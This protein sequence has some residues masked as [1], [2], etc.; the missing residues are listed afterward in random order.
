M[1]TKAT[2]REGYAVEIQAAWFNALTRMAEL[3]PLGAESYRQEADRVEKSFNRL[4]WN[5][6]EQTVFD[7][8]GTQGY[9][10]A[11][12]S[13][14]SGKADP[15]VRANQVL[16]VY[17]GITQGERSR[18][19]LQSTERRL[20]V[21]G[22]VR[23]LARPQKMY[24]PDDRDEATRQQDNLT[25]R[26]IGW[27]KG[28]AEHYYE[29]Y[30][31]PKSWDDPDPAYHNGT[32]WVWLYAFYWIAAVRTGYVS[33]AKAEEVMMKDYQEMLAHPF[34][35]GNR[36]YGGSLP[37]IKDAEPNPTLN[38]GSHDPK[39]CKTQTWSLTSAILGLSTVSPRFRSEVWPGGGESSKAALPPIRYVRFKADKF[40]SSIDDIRQSL[41]RAQAVRQS[42][43]RGILEAA[44]ARFSGKAAAFIGNLLDQGRIRIAD[45][46]AEAVYVS[47]TLYLD[48]TLFAPG[49]EG[50][51]NRCLSESANVCSRAG[52]FVL[53]VDAEGLV[54]TFGKKLEELGEVS[55]D[56]A[57]DAPAAQVKDGIL[58]LNPK[59]LHCDPA[60]IHDIWDWYAYEFGVEYLW[61]KGL[62]EESA[63]SN[64]MGKI[65]HT[66][67]IQGGRDSRSLVR[68]GSK[69][70]VYDYRVNPHL[71][72]PGDP[73]QNLE[74]F[75]ARRLRP[76]GLTPMI[77]FVTN[78]VAST[79]PL[80]FDEATRDLFYSWASEREFFDWA[81]QNLGRPN[82]SDEELR[83]E[84]TGID[85]QFSWVAPGM[86]GDQETKAEE[87]ENWAKNGIVPD[88]YTQ[89]RIVWRGI[90]GSIA[91][92]RPNYSKP[93]NRRKFAALLQ[94]LSSRMKGGAFRADLAHNQSDE[95]WE[96]IA[97]GVPEAFFLFEVYDKNV[98][99]FMELIRRAG[100]NGIVYDKR[101]IDQLKTRAQEIRNRLGISDQL[102]ALLTAM[103]ANHDEH[104]GL[105]AYQTASHARAAGI[106]S[107]VNGGPTLLP[108]TEFVPEERPAGLMT[109]MDN[110]RDAG[111]Y[112]VSYDFTKLDTSFIA[113]THFIN[114]R[115]AWSEG[116][117]LPVLAE[118]VRKFQTDTALALVP[119]DNGRIHNVIM[120]S[121]S[122]SMENSGIVATCRRWSDEDLVTIVN[123]SDVPTEVT[124][125]L[126]RM[127][128][129]GAEPIEGELSEVLFSEGA[130]ARQAPRTL[131]VEL[132]A[133]GH[134][135]FSFRRSEK[136][137]RDAANVRDLVAEAH[138]QFSKKLEEGGSDAWASHFYNKYLGSLEESSG[139]RAIFE[140]A[141]ERLLF[142][143][144]PTIRRG[145]AWIISHSEFLGPVSFANP[146][147]SAQLVAL[148]GDHKDRSVLSLALD[149]STGGLDFVTRFAQ[150]MSTQRQH[151]ILAELLS[152]AMTVQDTNFRALIM[153]RV[154]DILPV[155]CPLI[156]EA[157]A[158]QTLSGEDVTLSQTLDQFNSVPV[159]RARRLIEAV[160]E[161][162]SMIYLEECPIV[163]STK[164][165]RLS[166]RKTS[167]TLRDVS[168]DSWIEAQTLGARLQTVQQQLFALPTDA[169]G[170]MQVFALSVN[171]STDLLL[172]GDG[173]QG[174]ILP[175]AFSFLPDQD[176]AKNQP[177]IYLLF[178]PSN[179]ACYN[180]VTKAS[181]LKDGLPV[182]IPS[183]GQTIHFIA[184][185]EVDRPIIMQVS[186]EFLGGVDKLDQNLKRLLQDIRLPNG[187][188]IYF[189]GAHEKGQI[190]K[191][192]A[193]PRK[194]TAN[195]LYAVQG[196][197]RF[198][199]RTVVARQE[200]NPGRGLTASA[201]SVA[202]LK[203]PAVVQ[204]IGRISPWL[205]KSQIRPILDLTGHVTPDS[206]CVLEHPDWFEPFTDVPGDWKTEIPSSLT[207][208]QILETQGIRE[209]GGAWAFLWYGRVDADLRKR[210][211]DRGFIIGDEVV[212]GRPTG[213]VRLLIR[214]H[215]GLGPMGDTAVFNFKLPEVQDYL[216]SVFN[217]WLKAQG[218]GFRVDLAYYFPVE[219]LARFKKEFPD[220]FIMTEY[221]TSFGWTVDLQ[222][223][224]G[225]E[226]FYNHEE[227]WKK[228]KQSF[229]GSNSSQPIQEWLYDYRF[230]LTLGAFVNYVSNHDEDIA[231]CLFG[232]HRE[233]Y[234]A[235]QAIL[236]H[237]PGYFMIN[238]PDALGWKAPPYS[239]GG[240]TKFELL[241]ELTFGRMK[242]IVSQATTEA[243]S[244]TFEGLPLDTKVSEGINRILA[245]AASPVIRRGVAFDV[246]TR[247]SNVVQFS[248]SYRGKTETV[249]VNYSDT[250]QETM[251]AGQM[252]YF[253]PWEG[254]IF[255]TDG[256]TV[257][258]HGLVNNNPWF[259]KAKKLYGDGMDLSWAKRFCDE[260]RAAFQGQSDVQFQQTFKEIKAALRWI[261]KVAPDNMKAGAKWM[262]ET[263]SADAGLRDQMDYVLRREFEQV[264]DERDPDSFVARRAAS[265]LLEDTEVIPG[266]R[267]KVF[268]YVNEALGA[269]M[270]QVATLRNLYHLQAGLDRQKLGELPWA[271]AWLEE[272]KA[273]W[274]GIWDGTGVVDWKSDPKLL[275][276]HGTVL[277]WNRQPGLMRNGAQWI[278]F[279]PASPFSSVFL[280]H[281]RAQLRGLA[282]LF[283][284]GNPSAL[285]QMELLFDEISSIPGL[286]LCLRDALIQFF[287]E[288]LKAAFLRGD[289]SM[290]DTLGRFLSAISDDAL[291][292]DL[293]LSLSRAAGDAS[294][295]CPVSDDGDL[296]LG[297]LLELEAGF[298]ESAHP[299]PWAGEMARAH[300]VDIREERF[301]RVFTEKLLEWNRTPGRFQGGARWIL[302]EDGSEFS[303]VYLSESRM[304]LAH[305]IQ[306][307]QGGDTTAV[308]DLKAFLER[309]GS[310][311]GL[312]S[313]LTD[314]TLTALDQAIRVTAPIPNS[315]A[316]VWTLLSLEADLL[317]TG[318]RSDG[319]AGEFVS[320]HH[321]QFRNASF[322][323]PFEGLLLLWNEKD[324]ESDP[325]FLAA[326]WI[327]MKSDFSTE[328]FKPYSA[329]INSIADPQTDRWFDKGTELVSASRAIPGLGLKIVGE[330]ES[331]LK[332]ELPR[333]RAASFHVIA[334][335]ILAQTGVQKTSRATLAAVK[336]FLSRQMP[337]LSTS[338][339]GSR[340]STMDK[341]RRELDTAK[342]LLNPFFP[343]LS[344]N[345]FLALVQAG[346]FLA[347]ALQEAG[348]S[349]PNFQSYVDYLRSLWALYGERQIEARRH[350]L[351]EAPPAEG[352]FESAS[353]LQLYFERLRE[354]NF[355]KVAPFEPGTFFAETLA[356]DNGK[357]PWQ[358]CV[359]VM[360]YTRGTDSP[361]A[362]AFFAILSKDPETQ[363]NELRVF[364][365]VFNNFGVQEMV[366]VVPIK[367]NT[368]EGDRIAFSERL[369]DL[370]YFQGSPSFRLVAD[371]NQPET[372]WLIALKSGKPALYTFNFHHFQSLDA[373]Q[374]PGLNEAN[375]AGI[376]AK[377]RIRTHE[378]S[379]NSGM[380]RMELLAKGHWRKLHRSFPT[381]GARLAQSKPTFLRAVPVAR[382][383][384]DYVSPVA[385]GLPVT[386]TFG[387]AFQMRSEKDNGVFNFEN[388]KQYVEYAAIVGDHLIQGLP[389]MVPDGYSNSPYS[390]ESGFL[391]NPESLSIQALF[392]DFPIP[393]VV[394]EW[395][396]E[397]TQ[398]EVRRLNRLPRTNH[399]A[400]L[401][402]NLKFLG[403]VWKELESNPGW[404]ERLGVDPQLESQY[405]SFLDRFGT[406]LTDE[407]LYIEL[408][409]EM[410][411]LDPETGWDWR[412]WN[413]WYDGLS[414]YGLID[415]AETDEERACVDKAG[416]AVSEARSRHRQE[417]T[418]GLFVQ[419]M[420][421]RQLRSLMRFGRE[422]NVEHAI[423]DPYGPPAATVWR[424]PKIAGLRKENGYK[425]VETMG[426]PA[427]GPF[428]AGQF[429]QFPIF[430]WDYDGTR[431]F[432]LGKDEFY[433]DLGFRVDRKDHELGYYRVC[434]F[435]EDVDNE[436]SWAWADLSWHGL[437]IFEHIRLLR[438]AVLAPNSDEVLRKINTFPYLKSIRNLA[439][440]H[441]IDEAKNLACAQFSEVVLWPM[442]GD[443]KANG[444]TRG[445]PPDALQNLISRVADPRHDNGLLVARRVL[446]PARYGEAAPSPWIRQKIVEK[447]IFEG[448]PFWDFIRLTPSEQ[449]EDRGFIKD[450]LFPQ[451]E[452]NAPR[453]DDSLRIIYFKLAPAE[454]ILSQ[455]ARFWQEN[456]M[457]GIGEMLGSV[458]PSTAKSTY[459]LEITN[460]SPMVWNLLGE[461]IEDAFATLSLHDSLSQRTSWE[462][463]ALPEEVRAKIKPE[464]ETGMSWDQ[465]QKTLAAWGI[466]QADWPKHRLYT[467]LVHRKALETIYFS[468]ALMVVPGWLD[469]YGL[470]DSYRANTPGVQ[471]NQWELRLPSEATIEN[472]IRAARYL[473]LMHPEWIDLDV[474]ADEK[475][476]GADLEL[477]GIPRKVFDAVR[478]HLHLIRLRNKFWR[479][480][481]C[482]ARGTSKLLRTRPGVGGEIRQYRS[483]GR[484]FLV[485]QYVWDVAHS[486]T[487]VVDT[488]SGEL[489]IPM[490]RCTVASG[491]PEG[492]TKWTASCVT[493]AA[494]RYPFHVEVV[495][496]QG[497]LRS[498][499]GALIARETSADENP[500][501]PEYAGKTGAR[502]SAR[503]FHFVLVEPT[504]RVR[505]ILELTL[506]RFGDKA[507]VSSFATTE[508]ASAAFGQA[509]AVIGTEEVI[510]RVRAEKPDLP[511]LL[512]VDD[513]KL[514]SATAVTNAEEVIKDRWERAGEL[515]AELKAELI[516]R[517]SSSLALDVMGA[518]D[519]IIKQ[520]ESGSR[521]SSTWSLETARSATPSLKASLEWLAE[522]Q[523]ESSVNL[524]KS[525]DMLWLMCSDSLEAAYQAGLQWR[526]SGRK[527][528]PILVTGGIGSGSR[529]I[530]QMRENN[531]FSNPDFAS[532][533]FEVLDRSLDQL[534][535]IRQR[536]PDLFWSILKDRFHIER[537]FDARK[538]AEHDAIR[539][540]GQEPSGTETWEH[541][542]VQRGIF[543]AAE[544]R[545]TPIEELIFARLLD[546]ATREDML[547]PEGIVNDA[548]LEALGVPRFLRKVEA[549]S[550]TSRENARYGLS[551]LSEKRIFPRR[552]TVM[553]KPVSQRRAKAALE[554]EIEKALPWKGVKISSWAPF[555]Y[556]VDQLLANEDAPA[557]FVLARTAVW[558]IDQIQ[559]HSA[560]GKIAPRTIPS[561]VLTARGLL[562]MVL[563]A[564]LADV[565]EHEDVPLLDLTHVGDFGLNIWAIETDHLIIVPWEEEPGQ[566]RQNGAQVRINKGERVEIPI[567]EYQVW[568]IYHRVSY[569]NERKHATLTIEG[570][571]LADVI[572]PGQTK[573][574]L[575]PPNNTFFFGETAIARSRNED[576]KTVFTLNG[577]PLSFNPDGIS[578]WADRGLRG[579]VRQNGQVD[580]TN[581]TQ[582]PVLH[583][584]RLSSSGGARLASSASLDLLSAWDA[585]EM[586]S[587]QLDEAIAKSPERFKSASRLL[588]EDVSFFGFKT[589]DSL[590][591]AKRNLERSSRGRGA[592][593][594]IS[595]Q[596][597]LDAI[598]HTFSAIYTLENF[599]TTS[600]IESLEEEFESQPSDLRDRI[601]NV[602]L[603]R[604]LDLTNHAY[605]FHVSQ[606]ERAEAPGLKAALDTLASATRSKTGLLEAI[607]KV[608]Q[609]LEW[610]PEPPKYSIGGV[611]EP[612]EKDNDEAA[613]AIQL[614]SVAGNLFKMNESLSSRPPSQDAV[615]FTG[616]SRLAQDTR[617]AQTQKLWKDIVSGGAGPL[618]LHRGAASAF[619]DAFEQD[620][621][622]N[623]DRLRAIRTQINE[624]SL[625]EFSD[626][627]DEVLREIGLDRGTFKLRR[628]GMLADLTIYSL[629]L[630]EIFDGKVGLDGRR[631]AEDYIRNI[632]SHLRNEEEMIAS[633]S[634]TSGRRSYHVWNDSAVAFW[635]MVI[636]YKGPR[637]VY[638][639][640]PWE[641][642]VE[643]LPETDPRTVMIGE[644][645]QRAVARFPETA[646]KT[647]EDAVLAEKVGLANPMRTGFQKQ[648]EDVLLMDRSQATDLAER[649]TVALLQS[650]MPLLFT[651]S[652]NQVGRPVTFGRSRLVCYMPE[653]FLQSFRSD[654]P[655]DM[656]VFTEYM[657]FMLKWFKAYEAMK[658]QKWSASDMYPVLSALTD[659]F[660]RRGQREGEPIRRRLFA[661]ML[662]NIVTES[663]ALVP[664]L[665][666]QYRDV[667]SK[668]PDRADLA[669]MRLAISKGGTSSPELAQ[670]KGLADQW[671]SLGLYFDMLGNHSLAEKAFSE[672]ERYFRE[673]QACDVGDE[674]IRLQLFLTL[675]HLRRGNYGLFLKNLDILL[676]GNKLYQPGSD[677]L[678][679]ALRAGQV[680]MMV[681][682]AERIFNYISD[683][684]H[685]VLGS[686]LAIEKADQPKAR[687]IENVLRQAE[688]KLA[689]FERRVDLRKKLL[690]QWTFQVQ[691]AGL[692]EFETKYFAEVHPSELAE[693]IRR[694]EASGAL[695][696]G[697]ILKLDLRVWQKQG[698][699]RSASSELRS[700]KDFFSRLAG[701]AIGSNT[702]FAMQEGVKRLNGGDFKVPVYIQMFASGTTLQVRLA[703]SGKGRL[704]S[705]TLN[706]IEDRIRQ[707]GSSDVEV[708]PIA[709]D[710]PDEVLGYQVILKFDMA[711]EGT[712]ARLAGVQSALRP[713]GRSRLSP[714]QR[715][716]W[717][718]LRAQARRAGYRSLPMESQ[719]ERPKTAPSLFVAVPNRESAAAASSLLPKSVRILTVTGEPSE[720]LVNALHHRAERVSRQMLFFDMDVNP[721]NQSAF[722]R[723]ISQS[724]ESSGF[725]EAQREESGKAVLVS[726]LTGQRELQDLKGDELS[727]AVAEL[728]A[729]L[730]KIA[731]KRFKEIRSGDDMNSALDQVRRSLF[732]PD[733]GY[734][735]AAHIRHIEQPR[736][737]VQFLSSLLKNP[738]F[739]EA[740][741]Y[742]DE[743]LSRTK[744]RID[745][746]VIDDV[747][748][749]L[750]ELLGDR[751]EAF[752]ARFVDQ[753]RVLKL[754][755]E[756]LSV[757]TVFEAVKDQGKTSYE[758]QNVLFVECDGDRSFGALPEGGHLTKL[759]VRGAY[760]GY[761][762]AVVEILKAGGRPLAIAIRGLNLIGRNFFFDA[763]RRIIDEYVGRFYMQKKAS[764]A[765][766]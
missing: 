709:G 342:C 220:L 538:K 534:A 277:M 483:V 215:K 224:T 28:F 691:S 61:L 388:A 197:D 415:H 547:V 496:P 405:A 730:P 519:G 459:Q 690:A 447:W 587:S 81:R 223:W 544:L 189:V 487:L 410:L 615:Q 469:L 240:R 166:G 177:G 50:D 84:L 416:A 629:A 198:A 406:N 139:F 316:Q 702:V 667:V 599:F 256:Q 661:L 559:K 57:A 713:I 605:I 541:E 398:Q 246:P 13:K 417:I 21:P 521:L 300:S 527:N 371:E 678:S 314:M 14:A 456:G 145:A 422:R 125:C 96:D 160:S 154:F 549:V 426:I 715:Q 289:V 490:T 645:I 660:T 252:R 623:A 687:K 686:M 294:K 550:T 56:V 347:A 710:R 78:A 310:V 337:D 698:R 362:V 578:Q 536:D 104:T 752:V 655:E 498:L 726:L 503:P 158:L 556:D 60:L 435:A 746:Y 608:E 227:L 738:R 118:H 418:F 473:T 427:E 263:G 494:G 33:S 638:K 694:Q 408:K 199:D 275:A 19:I 185:A 548:I 91:S 622:F 497:I 309:T 136:N 229:L 421:Q 247:E 354:V 45:M 23:S 245:S 703:F 766:A 763:P 446:D 479:E 419:F 387:A 729:F 393:S 326:N 70:D 685:Y 274:A 304:K 386:G 164:V 584:L 233:K 131:I 93:E 244:Q 22:A 208:Q 714:A 482:L 613:A 390:S 392:K 105:E 723:F 320:R 49:R 684:I 565:T 292:A 241:R 688:K 577:E 450:Y 739:L 672:T 148:L 428:P 524:L 372:C 359:K 328:F 75:V 394:Q 745:D 512:L 175:E 412:T 553:H 674:P 358:A 436:N 764:A 63:L 570:A 239:D 617:A 425:R 489:R 523:G 135:F 363:K 423:D 237:L 397:E 85:R 677:E 18:L 123:D 507:K 336:A 59:Y 297:A 243:D 636:G 477:N 663:A 357:D 351:A 511:V 630:S 40:M 725:A 558:E 168:P 242:E 448:Q 762:R 181:L 466:P 444:Q 109:S 367:Y 585:F 194:V 146:N 692:S 557:L 648:I 124:L 616:G 610:M 231:M 20:L 731:P 437:T 236:A 625:S 579:V 542:F 757:E 213:R 143:N 513:L 396:K 305:L 149:Y 588:E 346:Q 634:L 414:D 741:D 484:P 43:W 377:A 637:A 262:V 311:P 1:D 267:E 571:R 95:T 488:P 31:A 736:A 129:A 492:V 438:Q 251:I 260:C 509:D 47:G 551:L 269:R 101:F 535:A 155:A 134:A 157:G 457:T 67:D 186:V 130:K 515:A 319:W 115:Q 740:L 508:E 706:Q 167:L 176:T 235:M 656:E 38:D 102:Q 152:A 657:V 593:A 461:I 103:S 259:E 539:A 722:L 601:V 652:Y 700:L 222:R 182:Q 721:E 658:S 750:R 111:I 287:Q 671:A 670:L 210:L 666:Q 676:T 383:D 133:Y 214:H 312:R 748:T 76:K 683:E 480:R 720:R 284:E 187:S 443:M 44:R 234:L 344:D 261:F 35:D 364:S 708:A 491:L 86:F 83:G 266:A 430:D 552:I 296:R 37:E 366:R 281:Y 331:R 356:R 172:S 724:K 755:L 52:K 120:P 532:R 173:H 759:T 128:P 225:V 9:E 545:R 271:G 299:G 5:E 228:M 460:Y 575:L 561:L 518:A 506:K 501:S 440:R 140:Q 384:F 576:H 402:L 122:D 353:E 264:R 73:N 282:N 472:Q 329:I 604:A 190:G 591:R 628:R 743:E 643:V 361:R 30:N 46:D 375:A 338:A 216:V 286:T 765:S 529:T 333:D 474:A 504:D 431:R 401:Q 403:L 568:V 531:D 391:I 106:L 704:L 441:Q 4:F 607:Q 695:R 313:K 302:L 161:K 644:A 350:A 470:D 230:Y 250:V 211:E 280:G 348:G 373:A 272:R 753:N 659:A 525:S 665:I 646:Q 526:R 169:P 110:W 756:H 138:R 339:I 11:E 567:G 520:F 505:K 323:V 171:G 58:H 295:N 117:G 253:L 732:H 183:G 609:A 151:W 606:S 420:M 24:R 590:I 114:A 586:A 254:R 270:A 621:V 596:G 25:R 631:F 51:L 697:K 219:L 92:A 458:L 569:R 279:D 598:Q 582:R 399:W 126:D 317:R 248:R 711:A 55:M 516:S 467:P 88:R 290:Q 603:A 533:F 191:D 747:G 589:Y 374:V 369:D 12:Q 495:T 719:L 485:D 42:S 196:K 379:D 370:P 207:D 612:G 453:A 572:R 170:A 174:K 540:G 761:E 424:D 378:A 352:V 478:L 449:L 90:D 147:D 163:D 53:E 10:S 381:F 324:D 618:Q 2:P 15:A 546:P 137:Q 3:D 8:L 653:R 409:K 113:A 602:C 649:A 64:G 742:R 455:I 632:F 693:T 574:F 642:R 107:L 682:D 232:G 330:I 66:L 150:N 664:G 212:D 99:R 345:V 62:W 306:R 465:K 265:E 705:R 413:R 389:I 74:K 475:V 87:I 318:P 581:E 517:K 627:F 36:L 108:F 595:P 119:K 34:S 696:M 633:L 291:R 451:D 100:L 641:R 493:D 528:L 283:L 121:F 380:G 301:K 349:S 195:H 307:L 452:S 159:I 432:I 298:L 238:F 332:T 669:R 597:V 434:H 727:S 751:T 647:S 343:G 48:S 429:W 7:I 407:L 188:T 341:A 80:V 718:Y 614:L 395:E 258:E 257:E 184:P 201:F 71:V 640:K 32:A 17:F 276:L 592:L 662:D 530:R 16:A 510:R 132:P 680:R 594:S 554:K 144:E 624:W 205:A 142:S 273:S 200:S 639:E 471:T 116:R 699:H 249:V 734:R 385:A 735:V 217:E 376:L 445:L 162:A 321:D 77:D 600:R 180:V 564:R 716:N 744:M 285:G 543:T 41:T 303:G 635:N 72:G 156:A 98:G 566:P 737:R 468:L 365:Y 626:R 360:K 404:A 221:Y 583:K 442:L 340:L 651:D 69:Y 560:A 79:S 82:A 322:R 278:L 712:G 203:S 481:L 293:L 193:D 178:D 255:V 127:F 68:K 315:S 689:D 368:Y 562:R 226:A 29:F 514:K 334:F 749:N 288:G 675:F 335:V 454:K 89:R 679:D 668:S 355:W 580:V 502:L 204:K 476:L 673:I 620:F 563:G 611:G 202:D 537:G 555:Q 654:S 206:L 701:E 500:I 65:W 97:S 486:A 153:R 728:N 6:E 382:T 308:E 327:L 94:G 39:G 707:S 439:L 760:D 411:K 165:Y 463:E 499:E 758:E 681:S 619:F 464:W 179:K 209:G 218:H 433:Y 717:R 573:Q 733:Y 192:F 650:I 27:P 522:R 400:V 54:R 462:K 26:V 268:G 141:L 754:D 112:P 325:L